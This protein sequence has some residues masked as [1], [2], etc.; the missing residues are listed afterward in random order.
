M[1]QVPIKTT[2]REPITESYSPAAV[3]QIGIT[4]VQPVPIE[5]GRGYQAPDPTEACTHPSGT[6]GKH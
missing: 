2:K 5:P 4:V 3:G 6:Q 1:K